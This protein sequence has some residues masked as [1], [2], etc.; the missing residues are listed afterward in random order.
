MQYFEFTFQ[1]PFHV[2]LFDI[3]NSVNYSL[4]ERSS[5]LFGSRCKLVA[6]LFIITNYMANILAFIIFTFLTLLV[7][8]K[9]N[10]NYSLILTLFYY[11]QFTL[12]WVYIPR[13]G[14]TLFFTLY[15]LTYYL[16]IRFNQVLE[17]INYYHKKGKFLFE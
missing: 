12:V 5:K 16:K 4:N 2:M 14:L 17:L 9:S 11:L 13:L 3:K 1:S 8:Y 15:V 6:I 10:I 7:Y